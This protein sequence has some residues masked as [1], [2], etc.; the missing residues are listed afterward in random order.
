MEKSRFKVMALAMVMLLF[1][2]VGAF[3]Q[4]IAGVYKTDYGEMRLQIS[5]S[6]VTGTYRTS[7]RIEGTLSG[8]TLTGWWYQSNG[9]GRIKFV[10]DSSFSSFTGKWSYNDAE[11]SSGWNGKKISGT[12]GSSSSNSGS[13]SSH[14]GR[15]SSTTTGNLLT[16]GDASQGLRGWTETE[17]GDWTTE[18]ISSV[19]PYDGPYFYPKNHKGP[20]AGQPGAL[21]P[22]LYQDIPA[23]AYIGRTATL[24]AV[25]R[26]WGSQRDLACVQIRAMDSSGKVLTYKTSPVAQGD[27][28]KPI[29]ASIVI[30]PGTVV[31]RALL[32]VNHYE[33]EIDGYID[34][35]VLTVQ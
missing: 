9:K 31:L 13:Q 21:H 35:A 27:T 19:P 1:S 30:P 14:S 24:S 5:G 17:K 29:S 6:T 33:D 32:S 2:A 4:N 23:S 8:N 15:S 16:N 10:F 20:K 7:D 26:G 3:A 22:M 12:T 25:G 34:N 28:W 11:P 18:P